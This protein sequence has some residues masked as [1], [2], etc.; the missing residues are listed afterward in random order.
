MAL[1]VLGCRQGFI[2]SLSQRGIWIRTVSCN[3][4]IQFRTVPEDSI[5]I[6]VRLLPVYSASSSEW[7]LRR[8]TLQE[9]SD[10]RVGSRL[11]QLLGCCLFDRQLNRISRNNGALNLLSAPWRAP[12]KEVAAWQ[13]GDLA[14]NIR[15][16]RLLL[17]GVTLFPHALSVSW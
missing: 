12:E 10:T 15:L 6:L 2:V 13:E 7:P 11:E 8:H 16:G 14:L 9:P 1:K 17:P 5:F 4:L 3:F